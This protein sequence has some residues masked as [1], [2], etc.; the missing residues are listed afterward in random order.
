MK[1]T[2]WGKSAD[3]MVSGVVQGVG[4]RP[5][6]YRTARSLGYTGWV[7]NV[8]RGVAVHLEKNNPTDFHD[9]ID[10]FSNNLPPL[11]KVERLQ[12]TAGTFTGCE[13]FTIE[14]TAE[15]GG[16]VFISPDIAVCDA[17]RSEMFDP[18]DRRHRYPFINCTDCGPRYTIVQSLPY[19]RPKTTMSGFAMCPR[20][21]EE[22]TDPENRRYHAQPIA[23]PDCGPQITLYEAE[24]GRPLPGGVEKAAAL[25]SE[26][27]ILAVKGLGGFHLIASPFQPGA[28]ARIRDLKARQRKPL[29]LMARSM[30][31]IQRYAFV[32]ETEADLLLSPRRPIVLLRKKRD[33]DGIAPH[34][35]EMG[36]MLPYTPLHDLLLEGLDLVIAT[37]SN[38]RDAPII[39]DR[40]EELNDLCD[41]ICDHDRPI[42]MRADDSLVKDAEGS[43]LLLRRARGYVPYPQKVPFPAVEGHI[44]ALGGE[45]KDTVSLYKDG[46]V[47]TSQFLGDLDDYQNF[48]YF[49]ET[50]AHLS[51]LFDL[52]P[53]V[54]VS[55]L[56][57]DFHTTRFSQKSGLKHLMVQH[58]F[59]H[60]LAPMLEHGIHVDESVL[61][62]A[63]DGFGYG[64]DG[65]AWGGEFLTCTYRDYKRFAHF[66]YI[67]LPGGDLASRQPWRMALAY[68]HDIFGD[69]IPLSG[70]L[71]EIPENKIRGVIEMMNRGINSPPSSSCG[72]L[73]DAVSFL[74]GLSPPEVEYEAEAPM[75]L[76]SAVLPGRDDSYD[77]R[78]L[79]E[80]P[81]LII[82]FGPTIGSVIEDAAG[83]IDPG[84]IA[85][86]FHNTLA[87]VVTAA[88]ESARRKMDIETVALAGGVFCNKTLLL[89]TEKKLRG[90]KF[91]VIRPVQYSPNDES[92]SVGQVAYALNRRLLH[93]VDFDPD[94]AE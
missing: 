14:K 23:C 45:L 37:S 20:C 82:D 81:S 91:R 30:E 9:F 27:R 53:E 70:P 36:F 13:D 5:F 63:F 16:F 7:R 32:S 38:R 17:C 28:V 3:L 10:K 49:E 18:A 76:E 11:A 83:G 51:R 69:K 12:T 55:D 26:G 65:A 6:I 74:A 61:G 86:R 85:S 24:T 77:F 46:Y 87:E 41:V 64:D 19:D 44:L 1:N 4:F 72:R 60:I 59:A 80:E 2:L 58:H 57:P 35:N 90:K 71:Q 78:L 22:Y 43:V 54:L 67:P 56:H 88:A 39:K 8:G 66:K 34:L 62:V 48:R 73:F 31:V 47:V 93:P 42:A 15:G 50:I 29:A 40:G 68:L 52:K 21:R 33:L 75:R 84:I 94:P 92:I 25:V 89:R 79:E